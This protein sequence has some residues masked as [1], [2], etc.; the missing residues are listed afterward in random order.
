MAVELIE[1]GTAKGGLARADFTGQLHKA[2]ALANAVKQVIEGFTMFRAVKQEPR[3]RR[4]VERRLGQAVIVK[5]HA[6]YSA[7]KVPDYSKL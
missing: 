5:I 6:E 7:G 3:V 1:H 2:F 4:D